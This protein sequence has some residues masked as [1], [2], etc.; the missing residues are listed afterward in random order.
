MDSKSLPKPVDCWTRTA[1][2]LA[3][4]H[5]RLTDLDVDYVDNIVLAEE[6]L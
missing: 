6:S 1:A 3:V 4:Q 2:S 5:R